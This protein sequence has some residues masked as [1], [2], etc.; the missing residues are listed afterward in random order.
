[1]SIANI[2]GR[3]EG[4]GIWH[5]SAGESMTYRV[6]QTNNMTASGFDISF[7][8]NFPDGSVVEARIILS[9]I[10]P[11][12]YSVRAG[13]NEIGHGYALGDTVRYHMRAGGGIVEV[14]YQPRDDDELEVF[15][16][17]TSNAAGNYIAWHEELRRVA[18]A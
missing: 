14:G 16:S 2:R 11:Y 13:N 7:T 5:D 6:V 3:Y 9:E 18:D 8:H 1:M 15:G 10:A 12:I 4:T 17:S